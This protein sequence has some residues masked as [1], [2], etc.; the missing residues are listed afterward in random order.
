MS[1]YSVQA[2][3]DSLP[4]P[5]LEDEHMRQLAEV[6]ARVFIKVYGQ[7]WKAA[8][9]CRIDD[10]DEAV[11]DILAGDLKVDWYDYGANIEI[12]RRLIRDS[13]YVHK[14][15]GS[16]KAAETAISD[17]WPNS[18]VEEWFEYGGDPY[19]FRVV[20]NADDPTDPIYIDAALDK[21][22]IFKPVRAALDDAEPTIRVQCGLEVITDRYMQ[23]YHVIPSGIRPTR[24]V[25]G[26]MNGSG[27][28]L[29][30][31][32]LSASYRVRPCG[33]PLHSLM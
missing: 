22:K 2:F 23:K 17:V 8:L 26:N 18:L 29:D 27:L 3:M 21:L 30:S 4:A 19:H 11:L 9:Y 31:G 5:I 7:R 24:A 25:H 12:K 16:R 20:L 32:G 1:K 15:M 14:R 13:W 6:A 10:L 33:T 28:I